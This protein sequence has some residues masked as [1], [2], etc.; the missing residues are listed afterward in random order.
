MIRVVIADDHRMVLDGLHLILGAQPDMEVV[1]EATTGAA[2]IEACLRH[3]PDV[4]LLD[5]R[6]PDLDGLTALETIGRRLGPDAPAVVIVTTFDL[7]DYVY[8]AFKAGARGF[9]TKDAGSEMVLAAVRAAADG[10]GFASPSVTVRL[11]E[12]YASQERE[13]C[14]IPLTPRELEVLRGVA[15]GLTNEELAARDHVS[16]STIKTHIAHLMTKLAVRNRVELTIFA[17]R[18]GHMDNAQR[19]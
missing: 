10:G 3:R 7:E 8:R 6:M 9:V 19:W 14:P 12:R 15:S 17:F 18:H 16:L 1:G 2:A 11:I 5:V 4:C 13:P